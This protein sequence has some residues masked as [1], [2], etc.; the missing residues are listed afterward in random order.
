MLH[1]GQIPKKFGQN[2]AK[3]RQNLA[4]FARFC[5]KKTAKNSAI[6]NE[7]IE[8]DCRYHAR[9]HFSCVICI[10]AAFQLL[11]LFIFSM[12]IF[13]YFFTQ[14]DSTRTVHSCSISTFATSHF[15]NVYFRIFFHPDG[16]HET[17]HFL[18]VYFR[19]FLHPDGS[20]ENGAV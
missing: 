20:H 11:P 17:F 16:F 10:A 4:T 12:F 3:I 5:K 9:V 7:K 2:L 14:T 13:V 19:L 6:F 1:F 8:S 15:L 18:N